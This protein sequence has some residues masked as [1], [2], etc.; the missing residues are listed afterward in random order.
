MDRSRAACLFLVVALLATGVLNGALGQ[1]RPLSTLYRQGDALLE[2]HVEGGRVDYAALKQEPDTLRRLLR[3]VRRQDLRTLPPPHAKALLINAYNL[4][5]I[6]AIVRHYPVDSPMD[7]DGFFTTKRYE[8]AGTKRSLDG[9]EALLFDRFPDPRLHFTLVCAAKSCP[10]LP[11][12]TYRAARLDAQLDRVTREA[13]RSE[14]FV[15]PVPSAET[16]RLSKILKWYRSDFGREASSVVAYVN[17]YRSDPVPTSYTPKFR[18]YDWTL[19]DRSRQG[20]A[21]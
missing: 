15:D 5:V 21:R 8:V 17:Q 2:R 16:V 18:S 14:R 9:I 13:L 6:D 1:E 11:D 12:S 3:Y 7:V 20:G 19:N 10:S 4:A